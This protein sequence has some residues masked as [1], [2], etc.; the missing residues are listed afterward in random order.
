M[1]EKKSEA[2]QTVEVPKILF[3]LCTG[4]EQLGYSPAKGQCRLM[5]SN[6]G[7]RGTKWVHRVNLSMR[8]RSIFYI[9]YSKGGR[10]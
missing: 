8:K 6:K 7:W 1:W 10:D 4:G 9:F 5:A 2:A 3:G